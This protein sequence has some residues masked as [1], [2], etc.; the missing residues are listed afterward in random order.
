LPHR[1][2]VAGE[3]AAFGAAF[4]VAPCQAEEHE[5]TGFVGVAPPGPAMPVT[6]TAKSTGARASAPRAIAAA[7]SALMAP[8]AAIVSGGTPSSSDLASFE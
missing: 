8:C 6:E 7:V 1:G 5:A 3:D 2:A 4:A